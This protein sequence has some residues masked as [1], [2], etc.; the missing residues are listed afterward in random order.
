MPDPLEK[1]A[2]ELS[3][4]PLLLRALD[5]GVP[6]LL[7]QEAIASTALDRD[8][9]VQPHSLYSQRKAQSEDADRD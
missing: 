2:A 5:A 3:V 6:W 7:A 8:P 4:D 9:R 1:V